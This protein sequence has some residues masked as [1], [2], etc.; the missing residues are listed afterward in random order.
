MALR[1]GQPLVWNATN[2]S[3]DRRRGLIDLFA[4]YHAK[5]RVV[6]CE[7]EEQE[8]LRRN[9]ARQRSGP[10]KA[11]AR[12]LDHWEPP[13]LTECHALDVVLS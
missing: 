12:M 13:D 2:L 8:T 6:Y 7:A 3:R 11:F 10:A 1:A 4:D 5:V 9:E